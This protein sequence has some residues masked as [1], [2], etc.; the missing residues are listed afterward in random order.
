MSIAEAHGRLTAPGAPFEIGEATIRGVATRIWKN[1]PP[2]LRDVF[3]NGM[4]FRDREFL[5]YEDDRAT[6]DSFGRATVTLAHRL[7]A[8]GVRKGDRVAVIMRNLPEWPVAFWAG[9]LVGAIVTPLNAWWTG[10]ELEYGLA[11]SG[12]KVAIVD[13]ERLERLSGHLKNLP[14]LEKVYVARLREAPGDGRCHRL[15]EVIGKV[16]DWGRL[17]ELALPDVSLEPEDDATILYTS[18]TTGKPKGALGTHRNMTSNIGAGGISAARN[19]LRA[20]QPLPELDPTKLPQRCTLLV[21]PMFHATGLSATLSPTLNAGGKIVLMRRWDAEP[22]MKLIERE[23]VSATGGVPTIAWQL[24]EHPA[25]EKYDLSSLLAVTY[26]GAPSAPELVRKIAEVF[27]G[28]QP[29]N[30]WGMTETT[31][32]FTSHMGQDYLHRPESAGPAAP[33]GEMQI[34]DPADGATVLPAGAVGELWVKGP[35]VVKGYWNKPEATA[36]TFVDGWLR[37]GDLAR[38][39]EEGFLFIID[40]AKDMLIRGGENIYCVEVEN[41]LYEHPDVMDAA[42]VGVPHK[43]LGEEP[44][45]VVHLRPGGT[46]TEDELRDLVRARLAAFKV[47]VKVAFWPET[48]P[49]NANGKI[50]KTELKKVFDQETEA[51]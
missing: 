24:I 35:Q 40:R 50:L 34:R 12:T 22:A 18:G 31:A 39:D 2:T 20:G 4:R 13:D 11:D 38:V 30:G 17:A 16:N 19:F 33:V 43:T 5:V 36:D 21:V 8:D 9:Q 37:T 14:A 49:R 44:A 41:V 45:A 42:I 10:A 15:E 47:P 6:F 48:L 29:G 26:G 7:I 1:A 28:S 25:R 23:K 3:L 32:T 46:A 51:A 27:P